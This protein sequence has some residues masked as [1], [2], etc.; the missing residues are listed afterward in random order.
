MTALA[1]TGQVY[2]T[3]AAARRYAR[4]SGLRL[5]E[6][7][8][9]LTELLLESRRNQQDNRDGTEGW[10]YRSRTRGVDIHAHI[11]RDGPLALVVHIR[12]RDY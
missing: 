8:R 1:D 2:A 3:L 7:R 10:R 9:E 5:E 12:V 4:W 6:A 11:A